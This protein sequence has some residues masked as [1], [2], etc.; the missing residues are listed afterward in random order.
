[1]MSDKDFFN[2]KSPVG[3]RDTRREAIIDYASNIESEISSLKI[4]VEENDLARA[5]ERFEELKGWIDAI[6]NNLCE[7]EDDGDGEVG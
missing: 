6:D 2:D 5:R 7:R 4:A 3:D 1:M